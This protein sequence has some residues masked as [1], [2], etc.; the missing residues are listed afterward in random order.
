ML[1][2]GAF[3]RVLGLQNVFYKREAFGA[4]PG[5]RGAGC[6]ACVK[7]AIENPITFA[8]EEKWLQV[9]HHLG[10]SCT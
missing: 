1:P 2:I 3:T 9:L 7:T 4:Q 6:S 10:G 8:R 5:P